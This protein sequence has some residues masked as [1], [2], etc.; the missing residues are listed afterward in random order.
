MMSSY[1]KNS[2][3]ECILQGSVYLPVYRNLG[4]HTVSPLNLSPQNI[5]KHILSATKLI[6][7]KLMF[8]NCFKI[9]EFSR[10]NSVNSEFSVSWP[11]FSEM[12]A[13]LVVKEDS[14]RVGVPVN[15]DK[16]KSRYKRRSQNREDLKAMCVSFE[17]V[18]SNTYLINI[19]SLFTVD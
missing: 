5:S 8:K 16:S 11:L 9:R 1:R 12:D 13:N 19:A 18:P 15:Q 7:T 6:I 4:A 3:L 14:L 2:I 17:S 10:E